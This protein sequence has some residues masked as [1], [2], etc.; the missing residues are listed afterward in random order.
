MERERGPAEAPNFG[1]PSEPK[2]AASVVL[3]RRGGKHG[4]RA[5]EVLLLKRAENARFMPGVWVF[6]GGGLD[7]CD[8]DGEAAYRACAV[9]E[10]REEA[11][12]ELPE[13]EELVLFSRWITPEVISRR[14]DAWFFL[15]LAPPHAP[16]KPDGVETV[17]AGWFQPAAALEAQ[18][19]GELVLAF[20][21][22]HQLR[23][24]EEFR[25]SE[26]AIAACRERDVAPILPKVIGTREDHR[27][28]LPGDPDY[29]AS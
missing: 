9:R 22:V 12:I 15:A 16:P 1:E 26:E 21:T 23:G 6:P 11:G 18:A 5:L 17:E 20:P 3:L 28:V 19:A 10:L 7:E 4:D 14:F 27:V 2:P 25:G 24:L 8:G 29:P 13:D